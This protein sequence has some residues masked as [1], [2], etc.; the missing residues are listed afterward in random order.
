MAG[1]RGEG[2]RLNE[3]NSRTGHDDMNFKRLALQGADQLRRFVGGNSAG[4]THGDTHG[5]I[6]ERF[7]V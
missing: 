4:D 6:V 5:S 7:E 3:F 1:E 2:K